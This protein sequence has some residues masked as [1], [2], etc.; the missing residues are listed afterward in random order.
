MQVNLGGSG[1]LLDQ[2]GQIKYPLLGLFAGADQYIPTSDVES[3]DQKLTAAELEHTIISYAG[4]PHSFFD[5]RATEFA[6]A[7]ADAWQKIQAFIGS[8]ST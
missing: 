1:T 4:A 3:F 7:S 5:R 2:A 8:H 6:E